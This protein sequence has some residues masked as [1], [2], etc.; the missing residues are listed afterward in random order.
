M[1]RKKLRLEEPSTWAGIGLALQAITPAFPH[2]AIPI[3]A[4]TGLCA[5]LAYILREGKEDKPHE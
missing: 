4:L 3:N 1:K 2:L 5:A